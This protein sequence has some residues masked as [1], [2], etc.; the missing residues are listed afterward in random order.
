MKFFKKL[1]FVPAVALV[2]SACSSDKGAEIP[3]ESLLPNDIQF[4]TVLDW[5]ES[6]QRAKAE[7]L[8]ERLPDL[9][10]AEF[11]SVLDSQWNLAFGMNIYNQ[12]FYFVGRFDQAGKAEDLIDDE[13]EAQLGTDLFK[14]REGD[15]II[16]SNKEEGLAELV[17]KI[18][19]GGG[20]E[21]REFE[22]LGYFYFDDRFAVVSVDDEGF[23]VD[24]EDIEEVES[25]YELS[26]GEKMNAKNLIS[27]TENSDFSVYFEAFV[28]GLFTGVDDTQ[29]ENIDLEK[30]RGEFW[31]FLADQLEMKETDLKEFMAVPFAFSVH[32]FDLY[33]G[34]TLLLDLDDQKIDQAANLA[35]VIDAWVDRLITEFDG[36]MEVE[37]FGVGAIKKEVVVV[38]GAGV[39]KISFDW[40]ALPEDIL[41][42]AVFV[43]GLNVKEIKLNLYYGITGD[44]V[45]VLAFYP[46]FEK[47][48]ADNPV[49]EDQ[50]YQEAMARVGG[51]DSTVSYFRTA[52]LIEILDKWME[53][54]KGGG[55]V[56]EADFTDYQLYVD[57]L[58][59]S[60]SYFVSNSH[61]SYLKID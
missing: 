44:G 53:M 55:F 26:L 18:G 57:Q 38:G 41:E 17:K 48:Y 1:L 13:F 52:P 42:A 24:D 16:I 36:L 30:W 45:F 54:A 32:K 9:D 50:L 61:K 51:S 22:G 28:G 5:S 43:P 3:L 35:L 59:G 14:Y 4:V 23:I 27:Y 34:L 6:E 19:V 40:E 58:F 56:N 29:N 31:T 8:L 46:D 37:G 25:D 21:G 49:F 20:F 33:P 47:D 11:K 39:H 10:L 60:L 12:E 2:F 7:L 15:L